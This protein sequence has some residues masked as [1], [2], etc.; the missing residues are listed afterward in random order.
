MQY[1]QHLLPSPNYKHIAFGEWLKGCYLVRNTQDCNLVDEETGKLKINYIVPQSD[2][3]RD[4]STNL[5][6]TFTL[7]DTRFFLKAADRERQ[8]YFNA[9]WKEGESVEYPI[10]LQD[11]D[12]DEQRGCFF[13]LIGDLDG[14]QVP[15][16]INNGPLKYAT[17]RIL[18]TPTRSNFWHFSVRWMTE[19]GDLGA[20]KGSWIERLLKTQVK[21]LIHQKAILDIPSHAKINESYYT[22]Y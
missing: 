14:L 6:G 1:P 12:F 21:T 9:L 16:Q 15:Y 11:F 7:N 20:L 2:H 13:L 19:I 17:C 8:A 4:L 3:L 10:F 18:H 22:I 5:L